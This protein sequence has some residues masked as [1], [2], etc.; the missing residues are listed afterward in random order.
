[1]A[2]T[3]GA[4][5]GAFGV[6]GGCRLMSARSVPSVQGVKVSRRV[7]VWAC[8]QICGWG[9]G[10]PVDRPVGSVFRCRHDRIWI[11]EEIPGRVYWR[12]IDGFFEPVKLWRARRVLRRASRGL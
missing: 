3:V 6:G 10:L 4:D 11:A 1:M 9:V 2:G 7:R 12:P 5:V 8:E